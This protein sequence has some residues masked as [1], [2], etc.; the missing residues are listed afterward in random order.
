MD[1]QQSAEDQALNEALVRA[2]AAF[3]GKSDEE[4]LDEIAEVVDAMR[5][6][7]RVRETS[8]PTSA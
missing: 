2:R 5:A 7:G 3:A 6:D 1:D 8:M 4:L